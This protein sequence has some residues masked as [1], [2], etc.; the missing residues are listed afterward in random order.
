M[1][2]GDLTLV[3]I[4]PIAQQL[5]ASQLPLDLFDRVQNDVLRLLRQSV[6]NEFCNSKNAP[7]SARRTFSVPMA[8]ASTS[9]RVEIPRA[10]TAPQL[11]S[12]KGSKR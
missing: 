7:D 6:W 5:K 11:V 8:S 10:A 2:A 4:K 3:Q 1:L 12:L 9:Q